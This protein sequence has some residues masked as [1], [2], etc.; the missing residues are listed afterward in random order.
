[1][2]GCSTGTV[3]LVMTVLRSPRVSPRGA[4]RDELARENSDEDRRD[5]PIDHAPNPKRIVPA[6]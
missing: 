5:V 4:P 3:S 2:P 6:A 1:V